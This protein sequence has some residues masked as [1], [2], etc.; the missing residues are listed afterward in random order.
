VELDGIA[1]FVKV[2]QAGSFSRAA[3]QLGLP[4]TTVSAKV[5]RLEKRLGVTLIQRTTRKLHVTPAGRAYYERCAPALEAVQQAEAEMTLAA[6]EPAGLLRI[7]APGDVAH[8]LL[9]PLV[10][11]FLERYPRAE[12]EIVV[13]NRVVDLLAEGVHLAIRAAPLA[14]STLVAR[15]FLPFSGGLWASPAYLKRKGTP[16]SAQDLADHDGLV[17]ARVPAKSLRPLAFKTRIVADDLETLRIF[18]Q[19]GRGI[20]T[21]IDY[22]A[23]E[24]GLVQVLPDW[25]WM[26]GAL[27]FVYPGQRFVPANVRAFIDCAVGGKV[28]PAA[29]G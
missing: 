25:S 29:A 28:S 2:V 20:A 27:S 12:V 5:A 4:N 22:L 21:L 24:A 7:T 15:K 1:I 19:R 23:N 3:R 11:R 8:G 10:T 13:A 9:P 14:D 16:R 26:S 6:A 18:A 17:F